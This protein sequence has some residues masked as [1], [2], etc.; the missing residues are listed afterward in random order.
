MFQYF[1]STAA[2]ELFEFHVSFFLSN[3]CTW[4]PY[5]LEEYRKRGFQSIC[6]SAP[7]RTKQRSKLRSMFVFSISQF[8]MPIFQIKMVYVASLND[9]VVPV[10]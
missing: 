1:E 7:Q 6:I 2:R 9:Q 10:W 4:C 8:M 3:V 5:G